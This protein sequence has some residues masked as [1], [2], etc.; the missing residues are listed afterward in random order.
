[1]DANTAR[2]LLTDLLSSN[3][4]TIRSALQTAWNEGTFNMWWDFWALLIPVIT[5]MYTQSERSTMVAVL[6]ILTL[7]YMYNVLSVISLVP[8]GVAAVLLVTKT[9]WTVIAQVRS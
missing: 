3:P 6:L 5:Y 9:M 1:M 4:D 2:V 8:L 7:G